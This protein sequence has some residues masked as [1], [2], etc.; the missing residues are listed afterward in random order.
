[1]LLNEKRCH[2]QYHNKNIRAIIKYN[3]V[4]FKHILCSREKIY[5]SK[6]HIKFFFT[7]FCALC[8]LHTVLSVLASERKYCVVG[9]S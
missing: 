7:Y 5:L 2:H 4:I 9:G 3:C 1:M 8:L 6:W